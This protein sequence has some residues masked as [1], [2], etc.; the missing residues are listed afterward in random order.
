MNGLPL[1]TLSFLTAAIPMQAGAPQTGEPAT[2]Q[3]SMHRE[4]VSPS[5]PQQRA[6]LLPTL[7][8]LPADT[9]TFICFPRVHQT[10]ASLPLPEQLTA[11]SGKNIPISIT[12]SSNSGTTSAFSHLETL[13]HIVKL[14]IMEHN[15]QANQKLSPKE[16]ENAQADMEIALF[17]L[18]AKTFDHPFDPILIIVELQPEQLSQTKE[19]LQE[20]ANICRSLNDSDNEGC[21][22]IDNRQYA[23][24]SWAGLGANT[25]TLLQSTTDKNEASRQNNMFA[26]FSIRKN[27]LFISICN[28]PDK[29]IR[30][31]K[32]S[33]ESFLA[34]PK[35]AFLDAYPAQKNDLFFFTD[36][37]IIESLLNHSPELAHIPPADLTGAVWQNQGIHALLTYGK[38]LHPE[39]S[40]DNKETLLNAK[41]NLS[42]DGTNTASRVIPTLYALMQ[43]TFQNGTADLT[44]GASFFY[45]APLSPL[46][47]QN[48]PLLKASG[49]LSDSD[50]GT[51]KA[52]FDRADT[53]IDGLYGTL[54]PDDQET[55]VHLHLKTK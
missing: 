50:I 11:A 44:E 52:I 37:K 3:Q 7:S 39:D 20:M 47:D 38:K 51:I 12:L 40:S 18:V 24:L 55:R 22:W 5:T 28:N 49:F 8:L 46:I 35:A 30:L 31:A 1:L 54:I 42:N 19:D 45:P 33:E 16:K 34:T 2:I 21:R 32:S 10:L 36:R 13:F 41:S 9:E 29:D 27:F 23:G 26:L 6:D 53:G 25:D 14:Q 4:P 48:A 17:N 43:H 15:L